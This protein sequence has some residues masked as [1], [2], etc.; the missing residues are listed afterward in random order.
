VKIFILLICSALIALAAEPKSFAVIDST[1]KVIFEFKTDSVTKLVE[2]NQSTKLFLIKDDSTLD[3]IRVSLEKSPGLSARTNMP[4]YIIEWALPDGGMITVKKLP[5]I[6]GAIKS[7][8]IAN[9]KGREWLQGHYPRVMLPNS[10]QEK[11]ALPQERPVIVPVKQSTVQDAEPAKT[12]S[13]S[14]W[15]RHGYGSYLNNVKR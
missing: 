10:S 5:D 14:V 2:V 4:C 1:G 13:D 6:S 11:C 15:N 12:K 7:S 9:E 8:V 3:R